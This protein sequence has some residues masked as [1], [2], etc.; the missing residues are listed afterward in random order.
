MIN[1]KEVEGFIISVVP[2]RE[3]SKIVN[4][5]TKDGL[6]GC[7]A[8]GAKSLKSPNRSI[9]CKFSYGKYVIYDKGEKHPFLVY[10]KQR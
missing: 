8:K 10:P 4:I 1:I 2:Y 9:S 3:T 5:F 7:I 6:I